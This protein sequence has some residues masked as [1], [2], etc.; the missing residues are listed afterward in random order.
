MPLWMQGFLELLL[1]AVFSYFAVVLLIAAVWLTEGFGS[2]NVQGVVELAGNI[3][4]LVHGVPLHLSIPHQGTIAGVSGTMAYIPLGLTLIPLLLA[5]MSG[6]KLA[7]A[8]YEGQFWVP[9][10][11]GLIA[12]ALF[13]AGVS[14]FSS[15]DIAS[16]DVI[17]AALIPCWVAVLGVIAGGLYESRSLSG[18]IGVN[19][20]DSV[21]KYSQYSR[22]AGSYVWALIRA[23][24]IAPLALIAGGALLSGL[25]IFYNWNDILTIYQSLH[26]G[27]VGDTAITFMQLGIL[28]NLIAY[29]M[30]Y[31]TGAGFALG[32]GSDIGWDGAQVGALPL[33]PLLGA[34]PNAH[35]PWSY[36]TV[37]VPIIAGILAGW[38]FFREGE[39]HLDEWL[40]LKIR[41]RPASWTLS[42]L[43]LAIL[44]G[45]LSGL[46]VGLF[47]WAAHGSLG[48]GK[49]TDIGANPLLF[50]GLAAAW[51]ALGIFFGALFGRLFERD[52]KIELAR[53]SDDVLLTKND[54]QD[55]EAQPKKRRFSFFGRQA[56]NESDAEAT[57]EEDVEEDQDSSAQKTGTAKSGTGQNRR[58]RSTSA[59]ALHQILGDEEDAEE[60]GDDEDSAI[61]DDEVAETEKKPAETPWWEKHTLIRY[62]KKDAESADAEEDSADEAP[63][64]VRADVSTASKDE[65]SEAAEQ[66]AP[67]E[68][69]DT[70]E[71]PFDD[72]K[73]DDKPAKP[74][75][76]RLSRGTV[77]RRPKAKNKKSDDAE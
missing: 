25:S 69:S 13:S 23:S 29:A 68:S 62:P 9:L 44:M 77:I 22:W 40:S 45:V 15:N 50:G 26:A 10:V 41:F 54:E 64:S 55:D 47:G 52:A 31:S 58:V 72:A 43:A 18:M 1:T 74:K 32:Q 63:A 11:G 20:A 2:Q 53:E 51:F 39:N 4:L 3:W 61:A 12:Y 33:L 57:D 42:H 24:F 7:R 5:F 70:E 66:P 8:S 73:P 48:L 38:W 30:S 37:L 19:A 16:T 56:N 60:P 17:A 27:A 49:F 71:T 28:P 76:P 35:A 67:E 34:I 21:R 75:T 14:H 59:D 46:W 6:R 65:S 36:L